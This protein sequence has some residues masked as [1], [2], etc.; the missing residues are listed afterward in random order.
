MCSQVFLKVQCEFVFGSL[1][2]HGRAFMRKGLEEYK[3][4]STYKLG[5][6]CQILK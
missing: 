6:I 3:V 1:Q 4:L 5:D 2:L